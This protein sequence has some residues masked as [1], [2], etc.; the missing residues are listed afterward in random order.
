M[1]CLS[2]KKVEQIAETLR[3]NGVKALAYHAGM[4]SLFEATF[5]SILDARR[6]RNRCDRAG[7]GIDKPDVHFIIHYDMPKSLESYYQ[8]T[9]R[10]GRDGGE[11]VVFF[12]NHKDIDKLEKFLQGS[13]RRTRSWH[14]APSRSD[15]IC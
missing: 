1:Y 14:A 9:G 2:R 5:R 8:E 15:G 11:A 3:V 10:A 7:M 13:H 12:Y 4:D 6:G